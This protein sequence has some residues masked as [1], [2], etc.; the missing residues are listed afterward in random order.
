MRQPSET[1]I[2][3]AK[4]YLRLRLEAERSMQYNLQIVMGE[5]AERVVEICYNAKIDLTVGSYENLP[6]KVQME[7]EEVVQWLKETIDDYFLTL[8]IYDHE[9]NRDRILPYILGEN[10]GFTFDE[11]LSDYCIKYRDELLLLVG[12]GLILGIGETALAKSIGSHLKQPYK[13]PDLVDG[14]AAP[15]TYGRGRTNSMYTAIGALTKFGIGQAWM[16][17]RHLKAEME[18]AQGF[19]TFRNSSYPCDICD[20]YASYSHPMDDPIPPLHNSCVCGTIYFNA[21]GEFIRL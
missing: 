10:H 7:I 18:S 4:A 15:L 21:Q 1:D 2:E 6:I 20:E 19:I 11:R 8:A 12:A 13:N 14:I 5:A 3:A 16:Y 17:D 9:E